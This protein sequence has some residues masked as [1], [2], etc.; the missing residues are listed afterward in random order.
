[1][2]E[3]E[4][5]PDRLALEVTSRSLHRAESLLE[6]KGDRAPEDDNPQ[7]SVME[8]VSPQ[9]TFPVKTGN[10]WNDSVFSSSTDF[11]NI[12]S[13]SGPLAQENLKSPHRMLQEPGEFSGGSCHGC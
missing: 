4:F 3:P 10:V 7:G 2:T 8:T 13:S 5:K 1:M 9:R 11:K 12:H 6:E